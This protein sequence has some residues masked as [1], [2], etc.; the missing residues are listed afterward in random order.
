MNKDGLKRSYKRM[1][2]LLR[3]LYEERDEKRAELSKIEDKITG[4]EKAKNR[5]SKQIKEYGKEDAKKEKQIKEK[6]LK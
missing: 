2:G 1:I 4:L 5:C 3:E 6:N